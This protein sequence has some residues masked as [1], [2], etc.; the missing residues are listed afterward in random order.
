MKLPFRLRIKHKMLRATRNYLN[1]APKKVSFAQPKH[2]FDRYVAPRPPQQ[3]T[4]GESAL[5]QTHINQALKADSSKFAVVQ[6]GKKQYKVS[7][8]DLVRL[9][10]LPLNETVSKG[11]KYYTDKFERK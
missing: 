8:G 1:N 3:I 10:D 6:V 4:T 5:V 11:A 7:E 9:T 2:F